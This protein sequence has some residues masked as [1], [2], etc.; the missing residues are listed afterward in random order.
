MGKKTLPQKNHT[1]FLYNDVV[2]SFLG[3][4]QI[5]FKN[6]TKIYAWPNITAGV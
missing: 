5:V 4:S 6:P 1:N 2:N 3:V